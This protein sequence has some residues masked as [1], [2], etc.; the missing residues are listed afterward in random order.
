MDVVFR[1]LA[2]VTRKELWFKDEVPVPE[3]E[4]KVRAVNDIRRLR[5]RTA[6]LV[7]GV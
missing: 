4:Q 5:T 3:Q 7:I 6:S 2:K 1:F